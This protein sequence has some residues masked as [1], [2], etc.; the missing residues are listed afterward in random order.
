MKN[1]EQKAGP[2][3]PSTT[4]AGRRGE[5]AAA[6]F[7]IKKGF[8]ILHMNYRVSHLE[9]D[10]IAEDDERLIFV[11]VKSRADND[12]NLARYGRPAVAVT[13]QKRRRLIAAANSYLHVNRPDK[14][15]R[16]DVI[17]VYFGGGRA[18]SPSVSRINHI[19]NAFGAR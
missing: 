9:I 5:R 4:S 11:E 3:S 8:R 18:D 1:N 16:L 17:E 14:R 19:E 7:L 6:D 2:A 12:Y 10:I 13:P 15:P